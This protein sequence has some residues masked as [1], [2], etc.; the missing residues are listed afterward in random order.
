MPRRHVPG[1]GVVGYS[2]GVRDQRSSRSF[3][4]ALFVSLWAMAGGCR[5]LP[6]NYLRLVT[7]ERAGRHPTLLNFTRGVALAS[8]DDDAGLVLMASAKAVLLLDYAGPT[9]RV[10]LLFFRGDHRV[11]YERI[12]QRLAAPGVGHDLGRAG[13]R[14]RA[15]GSQLRGN[16]DVFVAATERDGLETPATFEHYPRVMRLVGYFAVPRRQA[17]HEPAFDLPAVPVA[18]GRGLTAWLAELA[19]PDDQR[20]QHLPVVD[21]KYLV[22]T[23]LVD[24]LVDLP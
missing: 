4:V 10:Q 22:P 8:E 24:R 15:E 12:G 13:V 9:N 2:G 1:A 17:G 11:L 21:V 3:G 20:L 6:P 5:L 14:C 19:R 7:A 18:D 16:I 23:T